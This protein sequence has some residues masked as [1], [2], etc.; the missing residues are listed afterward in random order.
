MRG[1]LR[2]LDN[3]MVLTVWANND[4]M[5]D[6]RCRIHRNYDAPSIFQNKDRCLA[7]GLIKLSY[8]GLKMIFLLI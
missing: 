1:P 4:G 2:D 3:M 7:E 6:L 5:V 8:S